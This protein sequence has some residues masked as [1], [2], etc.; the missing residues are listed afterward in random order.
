[1]AEIWE[2]FS[3]AE[4]NEMLGHFEVKSFKKNSIIYNEGVMRHI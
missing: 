3:T 1:M 2:L 4:K